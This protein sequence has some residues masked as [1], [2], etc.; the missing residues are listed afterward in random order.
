MV[1]NILQELNEYIDGVWNCEAA[2]PEKAINKYN[3]SKR[4]FLFY[5]WGVFCT[6]YA[7]ANLWFGGILPFGDCYIYSDTDSVKVINAEAHIDAIEAYNKNIIKKLY[8]MC[9]HY[10]IDHEMLAPK[11]IKGVPKMIGVWDWESKGH[12]YQYF[13]SIG[14]KRYMVYNDEGLNITVSGVNKNTAV[15]Y[16][17]DKYGVKGSFMHFNS[18]L[19]IPPDYTGKLT[20]YYIDEPRK[21]TI[22]D[23]QGNTFDFEAP[24]GIYLEKAAYDFDITEEYFLYL[25]KVKGRYICDITG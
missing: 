11:T 5:P 3:N 24:S 14:S 12:Q 19:H 7:R 2:D 21:G 17:L 4:R 16:L 22:I 13:R 6:A 9:D 23:Y 10:G 18:G 20:H 8:A 1:T 25:E 15:P